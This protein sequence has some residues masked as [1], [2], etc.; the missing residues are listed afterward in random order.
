MASNRKKFLIAG[1]IV[2]AVLLAAGGGLLVRQ[3][4]VGG[5]PFAGGPSGQVYNC[6]MH[7][8]YTSDRPGECP[9]CGMD[10]VPV[11]ENDEHAGHE[12]RVEGYASLALDAR[13][14][15]L[16]GVRIAPVEKKVIN[17]TIRAV[18]TVVPDERRVAVVHSKVSGWI[19]RL[20]V[21]ATGQPVAAG[22]PLLAIFSPEVYATQEEYLVA[23]ES[24]RELEASRSEEA[25]RGA[26]ALREAAERRL[27][28]WDVRPGELERLA[29]AG[30]PLK[31]LTVRSPYA[32]YVLEKHAQV[33]MYVQPG[34]PLYA[35]GDLS[36]VWVEAD[37]YENELPFIY[38]GHKVE[39]TLPYYP[40]ETTQGTV[41][42][43]YPFLDARTRTARV[44]I[45][46]ANPGLKFKPDMFADVNI[47][48]DLGEQIVVPAEA[49]LDAGKRKIVFVAHEG[50]HFEPREITV[51]A[52]LE[53]Y[54]VVA[55]GLREGE[56]V[57]TSG[58]FLLD[59][60]SR[61][62]GALAGMSGGHQH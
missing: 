11:E 2:A 7:P 30:R 23:S 32:G 47:E 9:I 61:I 36:H 12:S 58:N 13:Q 33:G 21:D 18:G 42:F 3:H 8:Y 10:L 22:Q 48:H 4:R 60:E 43:I 29:E 19:D 39:I 26:E 50:G 31:A 1:A 37:I 59:S 44:R 38:V 46:V 57:V 62:K 28:Y 24:A 45:E 17:R 51:A 54:Y 15:Q 56:E 34:M 25:T 5:F 16:I 35:V 55:A 49:V 14:R 52:R 41:K 20:Y 27:E 53:D 6:P 40:A